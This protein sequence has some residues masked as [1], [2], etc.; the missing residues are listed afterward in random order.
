M[1]MHRKKSDNY[2]EISVIMGVYNPN[3]IADLQQ[4]VRSILNQEFSDF[5]F[6]IYNDG[7][8]EMASKSIRALEKMDHR[9]R[10]LESVEN[11]GLAFALNECISMAKGKYIARMD[12]DDIAEPE[13]F[14]QQ[15]SFLETHSEYAWCGTNAMLMDENGIWGYRQMPEI[16]K[17][18]DY[19]KFSPYIHP[20]VMFRREVF[21]DGNRYAVSADT[22]R[23]EDYEIFMHLHKKGYRGYN[24][25]QYLLKY[26]EDPVSFQKRK[27]RYRISEAKIRYR[28][29]KELNWLFPTGW[30]YILRPVFAYFVPRNLIMLIKKEKVEYQNDSKRSEKPIL[31]K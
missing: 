23:C 25:Q 12:A 29:F 26:R 14:T 19:L 11:R 16:P 3:D 1:D 10:V 21:E 17:K 4:A 24:L 22:L 5:E 27:L 6:I 2:P 13:R 8:N 30:F 15:H 31:Q 9:I 20:V 18:E 28:Y 7:S